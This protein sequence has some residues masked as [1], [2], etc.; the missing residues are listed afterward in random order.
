ML[1]SIPRV[2]SYNRHNCARIRNCNRNNNQCSFAIVQKS[3][4]LT[5][6]PKRRQ[7][8]VP[9]ANPHPH[10]DHHN[11]RKA[12]LRSAGELTDKLTREDS[13]G[14]EGAD[15]DAESKVFL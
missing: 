9:F 1:W 8:E 14:G 7:G 13:M 3:I 12:K 6:P 11:T 2:L 4:G 5:G 10:P 15:S